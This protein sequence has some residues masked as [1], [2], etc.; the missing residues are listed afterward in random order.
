MGMLA[1]NL[2]KWAADYE[3]QGRV[4]GVEE[5]RVLG[6]E[7][8]RVLGVE[9]GRVLGV[10]EGRVLGVEEGR[11]LGVEEGRVLGVEE[12]KRELLLRLVESKYGPEVRGQL[13]ETLL[14]LTTMEALDRIGDWIIQCETAEELFERIRSNSNGITG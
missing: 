11:V 3:A 1:E 2:K 7:E 5:G 14:R 10:E 12:G 9:E 4:L 13:T 8:G 6:V